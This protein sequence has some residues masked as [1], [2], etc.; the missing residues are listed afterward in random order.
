MEAKAS[1]CCPC[2]DIKYGRAQNMNVL[3]ADRTVANFLEQSIPFL[4][5]IVLHTL[6]VSVKVACSLGW[7]WL[8][9]R[10]A[11]PKL[12]H[13]PFPTVLLSTMPCYACVWYLWGM[14][15]LAAYKLTTP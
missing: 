2:E 8:V 13:R 10:A 1:D 15:A 7:V 9:F 14:S 6:F 5:G 11:Y 3:G 12:W 4:L